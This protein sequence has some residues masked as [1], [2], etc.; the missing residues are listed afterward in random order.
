MK[1]KNVW[2]ISL[3]GL[4]LMGMA[5]LGYSQTSVTG[6]LEGKVLDA[7]GAV[8]PGVTVTI[9]SPSM[10][11]PQL[12]SI[13][14]ERGRYRFPAIPP[15]LYTVKF[16]LSGFTTVVR[17]EIKVSLGVTTTLTVT[18]ELAPLEEVITVTGESPLVDIKSTKVGNVFDKNLMD[19]IPGARHI[20]ELM[21][22]TPGLRPDRLDIGGSTF[23]TQWGTETYGFP[24]D[25]NRIVFDGIQTTEGSYGAGM[26]MDFG[27]FEEVQIS[28]ASHKAEMPHAGKLLQV[29]M[30]SGGNEFHGHF[31][32]DYENSGWQGDNVTQALIDQGLYWSDLNNNG[33]FD[34][35]EAGLRLKMYYELNA[36]IGGPIMK[37]KLWFYFNDRFRRYA[38]YPT[39]VF[40]PDGSR[41]VEDTYLDNQ[42][43]KVTWQLTDRDK[44]IGVFERDYKEYPY[45]GAGVST[46]PDSSRYQ[47]SPTYNFK[48]QWTH[49]L[50]ANTFID[51]TFGRYY[52]WWKDLA[53]SHDVSTYDWGIDLYGGCIYYR[54]TEWQCDD[55]R[56]QNMF[57]ISHFRDDW[58]YG[59]HDFKFGFEVL[60][61]FYM[62]YY[63][64][65]P[66]DIRLEYYFGEADWVHIL[67]GPQTEW[68]KLW[69]IGAFVDD[70][71][72]IGDRLTLNL[73]LRFDYYG[74]Y[75]PEGSFGS[76]SWTGVPHPY[77]GVP[78]FYTRPDG[79]LASPP[80][81]YPGSGIILGW[82]PLSPRAG[83]IY[84]LT[85][86]GRTA[87]KASYGRYW[88]NPS[89]DLS[90]LVNPVRQEYNYYLWNDLDHDGVFDGILEIGEWIR[91][92]GGPR[93]EIDPNLKQP[94]TDE[95]VVQVERE[96][97][98]DYSVRVGYVYKNVRDNWDELDIGR[99]PP[100]ENYGAGFFEPV[101]TID[102]GPDGIVGTP[103]DV[104]PITLYNLTEVRPSYWLVTNY[105]NF[106][107][108]WSNLEFTLIK[109]M[110]K[111]LQFNASW[112]GSWSHDLIHW[113]ALVDPNYALSGAKGGYYDVLDWCFKF[114]GSY[115]LPEPVDWIRAGWNF[116]IMSGPNWA[117]RTYFRYY[118]DDPATLSGRHRLNQGSVNIYTE[119]W[120]SRQY[121]AY[122]LLNIRFDF[123]LN[124]ILPIPYG[125]PIFIFE[126]FNVFNT[127]T[128]LDSTWSSGTRFDRPSRIPMPRI[129]K[130]GIKY[131]F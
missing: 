121:D 25:Q 124:K 114:Y 65:W 67:G 68:D 82:K 92:S 5:V 18:L 59:D 39:G 113:S 81:T 123:L 125:E 21:N 54:G 2:Y 94:Y 96:L 105:P 24:D 102:P 53:Y 122:P 32:A 101:T 130:L 48:V 36:G 34:T 72:S 107:E 4:L 71:W 27:A 52:Y 117:R 80:E 30:K 37:D 129:F 69:H 90:W 26:Y 38:R 112:L 78:G 98:P 3:M 49:I 50:S 1:S 104:G 47:K 93:S 83:F 16:E 40:Y 19:Y 44:I 99:Y 28:T 63:G 91:T 51:E 61:E 15:G 77:A 119:E 31:Y 43:I 97:I 100:E 120:G 17:E 57:N 73:G 64:G 127:N 109:R 115:Q 106:K 46:P 35:G 23:G 116:N 108:H 84:D 22:Q 75:Y 86:D 126:L 12:V 58:L 74:S 45:R 9:S 103:D 70:A 14:T 11:Q 87:L 56:W 7:T 60:N 55:G 79:L 62:R 128:I 41:G 88:H 66:G 89:T 131:N 42:A 20:W 85:G 76:N 118:Y 10:I 6:N 95:F 110:S 29:I 111:G 13:T 8:L 33:V